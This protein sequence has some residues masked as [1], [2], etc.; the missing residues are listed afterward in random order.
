MKDSFHK[1]RKSR[2]FAHFNYFGVT[3]K[4]LT[5]VYQRSTGVYTRYVE[6]TLIKKTLQRMTVER[7][8]ESGLPVFSY[9][10]TILFS[11]PSS[12]KFNRAKTHYKRDVLTKTSPSIFSFPGNEILYRN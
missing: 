4:C 7:D 5:S 9:K 3:Y 8:E 6:V 11:F 1:F 12:V 2:S 10:L